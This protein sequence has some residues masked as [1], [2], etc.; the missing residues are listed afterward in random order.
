MKVEISFSEPPPVTTWCA[1]VAAIAHEFPSAVLT[2]PILRAGGPS[3][4]F[5]TTSIE[6]GTMRS[7][8]YFEDDF[9]PDGPEEE[10][11]P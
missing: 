8:S 4:S 7:P 2:T 9:R 6:L 1:L 5:L 11:E 3:P 10:P